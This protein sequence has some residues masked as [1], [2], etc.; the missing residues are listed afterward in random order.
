[1]T[2]SPG[3]LSVLLLAQPEMFFH[4]LLLD[5][6]VGLG[7]RVAF[8]RHMDHRL[9]PL[10]LVVGS[11]DGG[12][13]A[14][15]VNKAAAQQSRHLDETGKVGSVKIRCKGINRLCKK[16]EKGNVR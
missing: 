9:V 10:E 4:K 14:G 7:D 3:I 12:G 5:G 15:G 8:Q 13:G 11:I 2:E 1:M 16:S 6:G